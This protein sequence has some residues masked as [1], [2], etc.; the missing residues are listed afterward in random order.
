MARLRL[1]P[2]LA[3]VG[4]SV[5]CTAC[6]TL[7]PF[8]GVDPAATLLPTPKTAYVQE[9]LAVAPSLSARARYLDRDGRLLCDYL[10]E[11]HSDSQVASFV[12]DRFAT[13]AGEVPGILRATR[14]RLCPPP[15]TTDV[16]VLD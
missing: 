12:V 16:S 5:L 1:R 6:G 8:S 10:G 9:L 14:S 7:T 4:F 2:I 3:L 13:A 15:P 11:N